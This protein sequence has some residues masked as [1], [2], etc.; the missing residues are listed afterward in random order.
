[1]GR[2]LHYELSSLHLIFVVSSILE[3]DGCVFL[4]AVGHQLDTEEDLGNINVDRRRCVYSFIAWGVLL[5]VA[6]YLALNSPLI[7]FSPSK[8]EVSFHQT[9]SHFVYSSSLWSRVQ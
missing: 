9:L 3:Q 7:H 4:H 5:S 2:I 6:Q 1:M 8:N